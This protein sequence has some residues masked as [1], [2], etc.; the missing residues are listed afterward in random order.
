LNL[1]ININIIKKE[2]V[3]VENIEVT[4]AIAVLPVQKVFIKLYI[5]S[6]IE[7]I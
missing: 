1:K 7:I 6:L 5:V 2:R 3:R 4:Q